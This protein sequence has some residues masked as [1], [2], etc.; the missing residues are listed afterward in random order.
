MA[1]PQPESS[2]ELARRWWQ[3]AWT[4]GLW[5]ASWKKSLEGF[6]AAQAA[7]APPSPA[8][9]PGPRH[10][11]WQIV[12]HMVFWRENWLGRLAGGERPTDDETAKLNFPAVTDISEAAWEK[13]KRRFMDSQE[14]VAAALRGTSADADPMMY[15]LPHDCYHFGQINY[16]RAMQGV[17][18]AES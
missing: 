10:S 9:V 8:G 11:I 6:T 1:A 3:E 7:W 18:S 16:L 15:F 17:K 2:R 5:A 13:T 12:L 14:R 4:D